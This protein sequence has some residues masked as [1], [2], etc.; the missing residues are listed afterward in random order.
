MKSTRDAYGEALVELGKSNKN[1]VVLDADVSKATRTKKFA[2]QFPGRFFNCGCAEQNMMGVAAG[3]SLT[4]KI[5]FA[6]TFAV[7][8]T[9]RALDQVR[10]T[11]AYPRL[12]VK[13][14][15]THGGITVGADGPSHQSL[16]DMAIMRAIPN[17]IV[18]VPADAIETKKAVKESVKY[19]GPI[20]IRL[21]RAEVPIVTNKDSPFAIGEANVIQEGDDITIIACGIMVAVSLEAAQLLEKEGI[22]AKV[23]NM[24]TI[25]PIDED[26]IIKVAR[27]T[28][29]IVVAEEHNIIGGLG[30]AVA[31]I[32]CN[33][34]PTPFEQ[35]GMRDTFAESGKPEELLA[36]HGLTANTIVDVA[37]KVLK[38]LKGCLII[39]K[40]S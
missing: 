7:F 25:K 19:E 13:I 15:A 31:E 36:K 1:V 28:K 27:E 39:E 16:E 20:Y 29:A 3:L 40:K 24:H 9:C 2:E 23:V 34:I 12:N 33:K 18:I 38:S 6:S 8:A 32:L 14:V 21:G 37:R 35:V 26:L 17:M 22:K 11:I 10:N 30:S 4:G 5:P